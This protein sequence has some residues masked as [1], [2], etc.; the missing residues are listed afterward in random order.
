VEAALSALRNGIP[1]VVLPEGKLHHD[2]DDLRSMGPTRTGVSRLA[3][4]AQVPVVAAAL[5]GTADV[6]P[7]GARLPRLNPFRR[8]HV[9]CNVADEPIWLSGDDHRANT[10]LVMAAVQRL[11]V[12]PSGT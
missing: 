5:G 8:K 6:M 4:G 10:D 9:I 2:P 7:P 11:L 3:V 1:I 12:L